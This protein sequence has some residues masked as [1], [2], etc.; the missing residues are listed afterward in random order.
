MFPQMINLPELASTEGWT[1][2]QY[3]P[4]RT[5]YGGPNFWIGT[6]LAGN[7]WLTKL[8]GREKA[9]REIVFA[10]VAQAMGWSCQS[11][12][13]IRLDR[14]AI[15][16]LSL[17]C[18]PRDTVH[19]AHYLLSE[20]QPGTC[21]EQKCAVASLNGK[22]I[23]RYSCEIST[24]GNRLDVVRGDIST[25]LFGGWE[26]PDYLIT[27][28]HKIVII[29]SEYMFC[30]KTHPLEKHPLWKSSAWREMAVA[31][32]REFSELPVLALEQAISKPAGVNIKCSIK[33]KINSARAQAERIIRTY[34]GER[35]P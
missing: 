2:Q 5:D 15:E 28:D 31:I 9:Y 20:H 13:F 23:S 32:C 17:Y 1:W 18:R 30:Y 6:D 11:S 16:T 10:R 19:A 26:P 7:C 24:F 27:S 22:K 3:E 35:D 12:I 8:G 25:F 21:S 33:A 29:D 4:V 34:S 14:F